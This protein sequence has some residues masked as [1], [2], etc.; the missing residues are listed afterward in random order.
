MGGSS[1][2]GTGL[3]CTGVTDCSAGEEAQEKKIAERD[4]RI[5]KFPTANLVFIFIHDI[6]YN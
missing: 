4:N 2:T 1:G 6:V 3:G 5:K